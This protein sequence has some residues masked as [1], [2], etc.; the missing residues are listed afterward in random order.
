MAYHDTHF[1]L[2]LCQAPQTVASEIDE[3]GICTIAVTN[4]PS[5]FHFTQEVCST[6]KY[7]RPALGLHPELV[8]ERKAEIEQ[9]VELYRRTRYIGEVG[10]DNMNKSREDYQTQKIIFS[11]IIDACAGQGNKILTVHSRRA[12]SDVIEM[13]G[14]GFPGKII[15][16]W[17][18]GSVSDLERAVKFGYYFSVN[19]AMTTSE[20]GKKIIR[21][22]PLNR[23]L[24]ESDGPFVNYN[25]RPCTPLIAP[26]IVENICKLLGNSFQD[27]D[28]RQKVS[29]NFANLINE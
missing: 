17:F 11:K 24:I 18:S 1:H 8:F 2:D 4:S 20:A 13:I 19:Y 15:L 22:I 5:V 16:H 12:A 14:D 23:L 27:N 25:N 28:V 10:L 21:R 7:I 29:A 3:A 9:F 26:M 6:K